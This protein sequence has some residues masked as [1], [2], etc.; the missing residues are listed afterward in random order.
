MI[1]RRHCGR[2]VFGLVWALVP[3][4]AWGQ[5]TTY[6]VRTD[7]GTPDQCTGL[8]SA[9]YPGSGSAQP[10]AWDHPFRA[11]PPDGA[12]RIQGGDTL[13]IHAGSYRMGWGAPSASTDG[14]RCASDYRW[15]CVMQP[16]PSGLPGQPTRILGEGWDSGCPEPP[17]LWGSERPEAIL[18]LSDASNVMVACLEVTDH[19]GCAEGHSG[20]L[21]CQRDEPPFGDWAP[22][23]LYAADSSSVWLYDLDIHG[24][25]GTGVHAGR[26]S[27]WTVERVRLA[28]NGAAGWDGDLWDDGG[29][30]NSGYLLFR[31]LRVEWNG[32]VETWPGGESTGCWAQSAGGY[33]D[34][35]GTGD[36]Q[37]EWLFEDSA[38]LHNTSDGLDLLYA[39]AGS[40]ITIRRTIAEG[41]AGNQVKTNG[42]AVIENSIAVGNCG[43]FEGK[44]FTYDV[45]NCRAAGNTL[46]LT[47]RQG[48]QVTLFNNTVVG[49]G[50]CLVLGDCDVE[51]STCDGSERITLRNSILVGYPEFPAGDDRTCLVYQETFPHGEAVFDIDYSLIAG[52]KDDACLGGHAVCGVQPGLVGESLDA[53][54]AHLLASSPAVDAGTSL[55][56][57]IVDFDNLARDGL[58]D[59]GSYEYRAAGACTVS[60]DGSAPATAEAG[61]PVEFSGTATATGCSGDPSFVW[62][63]GDGNMAALEDPSHTYRQAG[64]YTW[65]LSVAVGGTSCTDSGEIVV[66]GGSQPVAQYLVPGVAH[67]PGAGGTEWRSDLAVVNPTALST[68]VSVTFYDHDT[69]ALSHAERTLPAGATEEW[70]DVLVGVLGLDPVAEAKGILHL[71]ATGALAVSCRTYN[72]ETANRTY[73]QQLPALTEEDAL[74]SGEEGILPHLKKSSRF[75]TNLGVVNLGWVEATVEVRLFDA[76]GQQVGEAASV[77]VAA[78]RWRQQNDV[79]GWVGAADQEIAYARLTVA[80]ADTRVWAYASLV[81]NATGDPTTIAVVVPASR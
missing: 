79:F 48:D 9:P 11:L 57:P 67:L 2:V 19:L 62:D 24:L 74:A 52:V 18:N 21:A 40:S 27:D 29:D 77:R 71:T 1:G 13:M 49:H 47:L 75:R 14:E 54:D 31:H 7:G 17:E 36:T 23:G 35:F 28:G 44:A 12:A 55:G 56:A 6:H 8:A 22:V 25:A 33:G 42:P 32:C 66:T 34:G 64:T 59:L 76:A 58:P 68:F 53:F 61:V 69:G 26:L 60:C 43:F 50:D 78:G 5:S 80:P 65:L 51:R 38:F 72:Q 39:R 45:D 41:N 10:C 81:D 4:V 15:G 20:G 63:F 3:A 70:T 46:S 37:G 30:S 16:V 73:G